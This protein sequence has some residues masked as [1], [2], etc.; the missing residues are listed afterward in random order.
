MHQALWLLAT[1]AVGGVGGWIGR[2]LKLPAGTMVGALAAVILLNLLT[3]KAYFPAQARVVVQ[4]LGGALIGTRLHKKDVPELRRVL[5]P[6]L[7]LVVSMLLMNLTVGVLL[8]K[9]GGLDVNTALFAAAPGGVSD[10]GIIAEDLGAN[11][12]Q[13][14]LLQLVRVI[15]IYVFFPPLYRKL[16]RRRP[17]V[18]AAPD[19][20][21]SA[22]AT[23]SADQAAAESGQSPADATQAGGAD[24][25]TA[26]AGPVPAGTAPAR[27]ALKDQV[28]GTLIILVCSTAG[29]LLVQAL[30]VPAG[31]M[32]GS[33]LASALASIL[34][35]K[36]MFPARIRPAIQVCS[37]AYI[38]GRMARETIL[39]MGSLALPMLILL[40][41]MMVFTVLIGL[42]LHKVF[43]ME[44]GMALMA[45]T[46][47][48]LQDISLMAEDMGFD[49]PKIAVMHTCRLLCVVALFPT[50]L[51]MVLR[52]FG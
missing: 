50:L 9:A 15:G 4:I 2:K 27:P 34:I 24:A 16:G 42:F 6:S 13:V 36:A 45:S 22:L 28:L 39:T 29:G 43:H 12:G 18:D 1:L 52:F 8:W 46:P 19:A 47:G 48:G 3:G 20:A 26:P 41:G 37:G 49:A 44:I 21:E 40:A 32:V 14:S 17:P 38:G 31:A 10:M 7:V 30:G 33:M 35:P 23:A 51:E 25:A 11:M 5:L